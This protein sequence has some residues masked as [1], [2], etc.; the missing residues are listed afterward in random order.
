MAARTWRPMS[1]PRSACSTAAMETSKCSHDRTPAE[2]G[3]LAL[4]DQR[5]LVAEDQ[6][7][8]PGGLA[9]VNGVLKG[10]VHVA[11]ALEHAARPCG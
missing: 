3:H 5:A 8:D 2:L 9:R 1:W 6:I 7:G 11:G 4:E 10:A